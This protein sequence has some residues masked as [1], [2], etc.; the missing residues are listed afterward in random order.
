MARKKDTQVQAE[1]PPDPLPADGAT[2]IPAPPPPPAQ[3]NGAREPDIRWSIQSDKATRIEVECFVNQYVSQSGEGYEQVHTVVVRSFLGQDGTWV[4]HG[5]WR[6]HDLPILQFLLAK[7]HAF[8]LD[9]RTL[10]SSMPF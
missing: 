3:S 4:R 5:N 10:D 9:R 7:A 6:T 1:T 8:A 2:T